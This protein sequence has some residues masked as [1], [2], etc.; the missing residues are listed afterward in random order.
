MN[1][2]YVAEGVNSSNFMITPISDI[3]EVLHS[4]YSRYFLV[5]SPMGALLNSETTSCETSRSFTFEHNSAK[6][7]VLLQ[8]FIL[9]E[10]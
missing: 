2:N 1:V 4:G 5:D 7:L 8:L 9:V 3:N 10:L 6:Y